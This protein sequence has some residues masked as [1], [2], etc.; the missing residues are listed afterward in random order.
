MDEFTEVED[1]DGGFGHGYQRDD[2]PDADDA[3]MPM[4]RRDVDVLYRSAIGDMKSFLKERETCD[5]T[6]SLAGVAIAGAEI[7]AGAVI[8]GFLA[9]RFRQAGTV[10]PVGLTLGGL[11]LVAAQ[12][13]MAGKLSPDL[14]NLALGALASAATL[15]AAGRGVIATEEAGRP[16]TRV[17]GVLPQQ[18]PPQ[19]PF[20]PPSFAQ[21]PFVSAQPPMPAPGAVMNATDFHNLVSRRAA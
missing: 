8:A 15:W 21:P 12:F 4:S 13:E 2:A 14:R 17:A 11:G 10:V 9:Q 6:R 18:M 3:F 7:A 19:M 5:P 20:A 1:D 16:G